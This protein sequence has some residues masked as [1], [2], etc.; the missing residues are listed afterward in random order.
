MKLNTLLVVRT[1]V[2]ILG[3]SG[4]A[5]SSDPEETTP[6]VPTTDIFPDASV[7]GA[8]PG[9]DAG[10]TPPVTLPARDAGLPGVGDA[11]TVIRTGTPDAGSTSPT[12]DAGG[13][14]ATATTDAGPATVDP[15]T[16]S[17][18][19]FIRG[20]A[21][22]AESTMANGPFKF[23]SITSGYWDGPGFADATLYWPTDAEPPFASVVVVPGFVSAQSD[24]QEWGPFMASHGIV[25][26]TIGTNSGLDQPDVRAKALIDALDSVRR[27]H[28]R[29]GSELKGKLDVGRQA[30]M[31][32]SMGG[33]G[34]LLVAA[35]TPAL[36][37]AISMCGY[38]PGHNYSSIKV[39]SLMFA[40]KGDTLAG[41]QSQGFYGTIPESVPKMLWEAPGE[42]QLGGHYMFNTPKN[43]RGLV[44]SY[45]LSW[46]K[47]YLEGD[48][49]YKQFLVKPSNQTDFKTNVMP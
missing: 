8:L 5:C 21:P 2:A 18:G 30:T 42:G 29:E 26:M 12:T 48:E 15:G 32:W 10:F 38:N 27:E 13:G 16:G 41:G 17:T 35:Q 19:G 34:S 9:S 40:A 45:G 22:T 23:K 46:M 14:A 20:P 11:G 4:A 43:Q 36:K 7:P 24:I 39:P 37:A 28:M 25:A 1:M 44:G 3:V 33:G 47:V 6:Q 31:G 49:R